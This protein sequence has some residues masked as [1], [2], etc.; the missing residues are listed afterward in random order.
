[1]DCFALLAMTEWIMWTLALSGLAASALLAS[2]ASAQA[3]AP[4]KLLVVLSVDQLSSDL[5][6]QYRPHFTGGFRR[7][8]GGV[9]F[10][11]GYQ[12]HAATE[13]C[14]GHSTILTGLRPA[15]NGIVANNWVDNSVRREKKEVYCAE[16]VE[17]S[18]AAG[19]PTDHVVS[20]VNMTGATLGEL[21]KSARPG[22]RTVAIAGKDR[23]AAMMGGRAP[24]QRWYFAKNG[25]Y[26]DLSVAPPQSLLRTRAALER[27]LAA[28]SPGLEP[29]PLCAA[30]ARTYVIAE[31]KKT[32]GNGRFAREAGKWSDFQRSPEHDGAVLALGAS[33]VQEMQL[34]RGPSTAVLALGLAATDYVGHTYG[35]GGQEMCLQLLSLDRDLG[36]F[37]ALL[38]GL[39]VDYAVALTADHGGMDIPARVP[40]AAY[41]DKALS[42]KAAGEAIGKS[43][44]IPGEILAGDIGGDYWI[45][46]RVSA[47]D[48]PRVL[49]AAVDY[50]EKHAQVEDVFTATEI[51]VVPMPTDNPDRW[52]LAQRS[53]DLLVV[54]K[55]NVIPLTTASET[56]GTHGT[57]WDRDRRVPI[58]FWRKGWQASERAEPIETVDIMPTLAA[59]SGVALT[60]G[61]VDGRC[62]P[63]I[64]GAV[65]G[66]GAAGERGRR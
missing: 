64:P 42:A 48:R 35:P 40:G 34:G 53:G 11:N 3:P 39:G 13:T 6:E 15:R 7:L 23:S 44:G 57:A 27:A 12:S 5:F 25:F 50:F 46:H 51:A 33:L 20:T 62:L 30:K 54:L 16:D 26:T 38:D 1:M 32:V 10:R 22:S 41:A 31:G 65:C 58:I 18:P 55:E 14:P 17:R 9:V 19:S 60:P 61:S 66:D 45:D 8:S 21:L 52:T 24:D 2:Q 4:P 56:A 47:A 29:P 36:D 43:L 63:G 37:F 59:M 28:P 49:K